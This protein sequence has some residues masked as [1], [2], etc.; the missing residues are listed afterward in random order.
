[1]QTYGLNWILL[2]TL[3]GALLGFGPD[4]SPQAHL[5]FPEIHDWNSLRITLN[6]SG[7]YGRCPAYE[8]EI[9]GDGTVLYEGKANVTTKGKRTGKISHA[10]LI[11]LVDVFRKADYF[12]LAEHYVSGVTDNPTYVS[13]ISFDGMSKSVLD[14]VGRDVGMP[15]TVSE[16]EV[17][18]DRL[19]GAHKWIGRE[20]Q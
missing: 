5:P 19:S 2:A 10:T 18:I 1:M 15:S 8:I 13:S 20:R 14:Y 12:S 3:L 11:D 9:H 4:S 17:A 7:C 6:R 16:I